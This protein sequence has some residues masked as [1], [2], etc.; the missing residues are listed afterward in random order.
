MCLWC[1]FIHH[2]FRAHVNRRLRNLGLLLSS[3]YILLPGAYLGEPSAVRLGPLW[4]WKKFIL[5]FNVKKFLCLI[6]NTFE[7][8]APL[9]IGHPPFHISK[10]T[11]VCYTDVLKFKGRAQIYLKHRQNN[12]AEGQLCNIIILALTSGCVSRHRR[13]FFRAAAVVLA[14]N[15]LNF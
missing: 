5:I 15:V 3:I 4:R 1:T 7:H 12:F 14:F 9:K 11:T 10:Y 2:N 8:N 13:F 6:W